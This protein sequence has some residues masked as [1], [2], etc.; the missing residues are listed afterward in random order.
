M[1]TT[2][3]RA[4]LRVSEINHRSFDSLVVP[5]STGDDMF[6]ANAIP[7]AAGYWPGTNT[8]WH[9]CDGMTERR[10]TTPHE[11]ALKLT[12]DGM[13]I[14]LLALRRHADYY[15]QLGMA[16]DYMATEMIRQTIERQ[17]AES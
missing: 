13:H 12:D 16:A 5:F 2:D 17:A 9:Y 1:S 15:R 4:P 6:C 10:K 7:H 14:V 3:Q 8:E 11:H